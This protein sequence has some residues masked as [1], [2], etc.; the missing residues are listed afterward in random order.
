MS[1]SGLRV[2][3]LESRRANETA[4]LIR[5]QQGEPVIAPS[6]REVPLE[7]NH[8]AIRFGERLLHGDFDMTIFMTGVGTRLLIKVL[9]AHFPPEEIRQAIGRTTTVV[10]GPKPASA[11]RELGLSPALNAPEPNTWH[12]VLAVTEGRPERRIAV[13]EYGRPSS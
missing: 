10:R 9:D 7:S 4:E 3:S 6:M 13:Q 2:L 12:E 8:D 11:I 1:L 5:R